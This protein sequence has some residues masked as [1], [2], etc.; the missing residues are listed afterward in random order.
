MR[1]EQKETHIVGTHYYTPFHEIR[2]NKDRPYIDNLLSRLKD[3]FE[4]ADKVIRGLNIVASAVKGSNNY[5]Y[6]NWERTT[7]F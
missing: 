3:Q 4:E 1:E 6:E 7:N 2:I 5:S